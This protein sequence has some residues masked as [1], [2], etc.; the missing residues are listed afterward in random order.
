MRPAHILLARR[1][2]GKSDSYLVIYSMQGQE[3]GWLI[4]GIDLQG[5]L[6]WV[7]FSVP[8]QTDGQWLKREADGKSKGRSEH[9]EQPGHR[10]SIV[11]SLPV[12]SFLLL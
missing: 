12:L 1:V 10:K 6:R 8:S 4:H 3:K 11:R 9:R 7:A 5:A 2:N